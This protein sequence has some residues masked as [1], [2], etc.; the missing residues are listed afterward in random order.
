M[1]TRFSSI[2][3][4]SALIF[5]A[6]PLVTRILYGDDIYSYHQM[7]GQLQAILLFGIMALYYQQEEKK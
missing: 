1:K 5:Y 7:I 6:G 2:F 3:L 4:F